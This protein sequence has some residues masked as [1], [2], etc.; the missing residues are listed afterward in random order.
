MPR[1]PRY[2]LPNVPVHIVMRG[3]NRKVIFAEQA[4]YQAFLSWFKEAAAKHSCQVH[5]Y[6]LMSNHVH[7]LI[8]SDNPKS[9][10]KLPQ[11]IG[12]RYVPYF[13]HKYDSSGTLWE[14]R[15]KASSIDSECYLFRCYRYIELN[16]VRAN[17][18]ESP[19]DYPWSSYGC[20]ALGSNDGLITPHPHY[21]KLGEDRHQCAN[22]Y[23]GLFKEHLDDA[24][25]N[26]IRASLQTGTPLGS[27][28]FKSEVES[29]L[30][31]KVG[32]SRR[33]RPTKKKSIT[34]KPE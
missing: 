28:R 4:D 33:G 2:F 30:G 16:P 21:L 18:V 15:F 31:V 5:A 26:E 19:D 12:R 7:L 20:N 17:M 34:T 14:G 9:L 11:D 3:N 24:L 32:Q 8:S 6:V 25:V 13:N 22:N 29:L 10:S 27:E 1:K 23:R